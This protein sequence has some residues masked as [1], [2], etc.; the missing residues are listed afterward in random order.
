MS[1]SQYAL[2]PT[3]VSAP[4]A[5]SPYGA[6]PVTYMPAAATAAGY[7]QYMQYAQSPQ[8]HGAVLSQ[9]QYIVADTNHDGMVSQQEL[10]AAAPMKHGLFGNHHGLGIY[11][12]FVNHGA[13]A[14]P[15]Y[16][17]AP[18]TG[19]GYQQYAQYAHSPQYHGAVLTQQQ[20]VQAD[21]NHDGR[22]SVAEIQQAQSVAAQPAAMYQPM[23]PASMYQ[24]APAAFPTASSMVAYPAV[25]TY[26][27]QYQQYQQQF[28]FAAQ[29]QLSV[30]EFAQADTNHDGRVSKQEIAAE[31]AL[32]TSKSSKKKVSKKKKK[33][34]CC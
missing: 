3:T 5:A 10:T 8:Y 33:G 30:Q 15:T 23:Q 20:F 9:Q 14:Q 7:E 29:P 24:P 27:P 16:T 1:I 18:A 21:A 4:Y 26:T 6:A 12:H 34:G 11:D 31:T 17:Y 2:A 13:A 32:V 25:Q 22:I 19:Q 28:Q